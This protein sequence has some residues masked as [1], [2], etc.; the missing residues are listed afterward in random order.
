VT[1]SVASVMLAALVVALAVELGARWWLQRRT[2]YY[3]WPPRYR[4]ELR[5]SPEV[6]PQIEPR[7]RFEINADGERGGEVDR[8]EAGLL[9]ILVAGGSAVECLA[10]DQPTSWPGAL[11]R[12]LNAPENRRILGARRVH[13]GNIG[14]SGIGSRELDLIFERVLPRY[15][16]L[17]GIVVMVGA[18]DILGWLEQG[19][20]ASLGSAAA[21]ATGTFECHPEQRF[22]WRPRAWATLEVARRLRRSWWRP[23]DLRDPAGG[24][25]VAARTMRAQAKELR[26]SVPDPTPPLERFTYHFRRLLQRA[27]AH[28]DRVLVARQPWFEKEY[29]AEEV[30]HFWH[31]GLGKAWKERITV[32]YSLPVMNRLMGLL[33]ARAAAVADE[34]GIEHLDLNRSLAP[35]LTHYFDSFHYTPAGAAVVARAVAAAWVHRPRAPG[36][37]VARP[38]AESAAL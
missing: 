13:V 38:I 2:G 34:L 3:V 8:Q 22:G 23:L 5:Q 37:S 28:A 9:R 15:G 18:S 26:T 21:S 36:G 24:W 7:V 31:G 25:I 16:R 14:R 32:Y 30:A 33:D 19:T 35:S 17:A 1:A 11:E 27:Q 12:L 10:L 29:T 20:P 6:S 4:L